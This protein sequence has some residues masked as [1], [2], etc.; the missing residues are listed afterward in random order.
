MD[1]KVEVIDE[2]R[3]RKK[4]APRS[5]TKCPKCGEN[6]RTVFSTL[7]V[8]GMRAYDGFLGCGKCAEIYKVMLAGVPIINKEA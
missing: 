4:Y 2:T 5:G 6:M 1:E 8:G 3:K 7:N